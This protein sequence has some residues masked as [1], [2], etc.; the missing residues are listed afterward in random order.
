MSRRCCPAARRAGRGVGSGCVLL[1]LVP[2]RAGGDPGRSG[3]RLAGRSPE[4][5]SAHLRAAP[6]DQPARR[7]H[8]RRK[9][10]HRGQRPRP[11]AL[12]S[13]LR[14]VPR[15]ARCEREGALRQ[16]HLCRS[17][18]RCPGL[19][20]EGQAPVRR[21]AHS[22]GEVDRTEP[23]RVSRARTPATTSRRPGARRRAGCSR[24]R[25]RPARTA[26]APA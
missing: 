25:S 1:R 10:R 17:T 14:R 22:S 5:R 26:S 6:R 11:D 19:L 3:L 18:C 24:H 21:S 4:G 2:P 16:G 15:A 7:S 20:V 8:P 13:D 9:A 12:P 23:Y